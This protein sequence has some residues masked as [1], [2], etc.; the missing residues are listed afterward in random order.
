MTGEDKPLTLRR[1]LQNSR[2]LSSD[3]SAGFDPNFAGVFEKRNASIV[4]NNQRAV[5]A[6][7]ESYHRIDESQTSGPL[8][9][10]AQDEQQE[11]SK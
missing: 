3:V 1:C 11:N 9:L 8:W 4:G 6:L 5:R 2:M 7:L 10:E